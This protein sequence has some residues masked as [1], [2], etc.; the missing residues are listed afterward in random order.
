M[1]RQWTVDDLV[2]QWT[3][4]PQELALLANK[5]GHTRLG[6]AL[7]LKF[8]QQE[9]RFPQHKH[10]IP[11]E[12]ITHVAKQVGVA[13]DQFL[14]YDW[15]SRAIKY[16]RAQIRA[17]F[18]FREATVDDAADLAVWLCQQVLP[19]DHRP[20]ILRATVYRR[21]RELRVEPPTTGRIDRIT[22]S[23]LHQ[24]ETQFFAATLAKL[25]PTTLARIDAL[26]TD[27]SAPEDAGAPPAV[28]LLELRSD[29][30]QVGLDTMLAELAKLERIRQLALPPDL[31][32]QVTPKVL[33][34]YRQRAAAEPP[35][36]LRK[37]PAPT[38]YTLICALCWLRSQEITDTLVDVLIQIIQRISRRAEQRVEQEVL[39]DLRRV[40]GKT[41]LL[42]HIAEAAVTHP[43]GKVAE[44]I[45]P[46]V[47]ERTLQ[48]L[49]KE[50]RATGP[51]YRR[52]I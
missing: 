22:R 44:V 17:F 28:S 10:E 6:F 20:D 47:S 27:D 46:V 36:E 11:L 41:T 49:V 14:Q 43:D 38:R 26:L 8:F 1:T 23:A 33:Q 19:Y 34:K 50:Y 25:S 32:Q 9:G 42:F 5:T 37:H 40:G 51:T 2:E 21:C 31:F 39:R 29:P 13:T 18:G 4:L 7:L 16:H 12:V 15:R 3:L 45:F 52:H 35:G 24:Y 30:G 48:E